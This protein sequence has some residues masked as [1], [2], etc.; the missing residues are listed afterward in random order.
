MASVSKF[1]CKTVL[2]AFFYFPILTADVLG[3]TNQCPN[4]W[5][6]VTRQRLVTNVNVSAQIHGYLEFLPQGY[7]PNASQTYPLIINVHGRGARG[8]GRDVANLCVV[9]CEGLSIIIEQFRFPE[10]VYKNGQPYRFIVLSPQYDWGDQETAADLDAFITY[11][12]ANYK[13]D[14]NRVYLTGLSS[15]ANLIM[16]Y[17][18]L[19]AAK[20]N[21]IAA[22]NTISV[23]NGPNNTTANYLGSQ[24]IGYWGIHGSNDTQCSNWNSIAWTNSIN[25]YGSGLTLAKYSLYSGQNPDQHVIWPDVQDSVYKVNNMNIPQW[26]IQYS[27]AAA[28]T[29]PA[30]LKSYDVTLKGKTVVTSWTSNQESN[31]SH[32]IIERSGADM[33]FKTIGQVT[34]AGNSS[35]TI[36][37]SFTDVNPLK[38]TSFY[39]IG[40]VNRDG[41]IEY[42][43][44]K[45]VLNK[46]AGEAFVLGTGGQQQIITLSFEL[47]APQK[48][49]WVIRDLNGKMLGR[50]SGQF[51]SGFNSITLNINNLSKGVYYLTAY[52][53]EA[54]ETK[55]FLR[56]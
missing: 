14:V 37:Y 49:E 25:S 48:V 11:A 40:L 53:G 51:T 46:G 35:N 27:K 23:C 24:R 20:A 34:A 52:S 28:S 21:R 47:D 10:L 39:R 6:P 3:Q 13:V 43:D 55:K 7:N 26:M 18:G 19:S 8:S 45:K 32:F 38:G 12:L 30:S 17:M 31:S 5:V 50:Q 41:Q 56:Y 1:L 2:F 16:S 44:I 22:V 42:F 54:V 33:V 9:A 15:G 29:L 36:A 4:C